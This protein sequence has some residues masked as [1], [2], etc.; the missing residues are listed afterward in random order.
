MIYDAVMQAIADENGCF[1]IDGPGG[2]GKTFLYNTL[3][4]SIRSSG[5]IAVAVASSGIAA[6]LIMSGRTAHN[7]FKIPLKLNES[8]TCNILR[9]SKEAQLI[10]LAKLFIW[11]EA[12]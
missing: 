2:T 8:S 5:E 9:N 10:H 12:L 6:L 3:L 11:D 1:F 4:A 7:W